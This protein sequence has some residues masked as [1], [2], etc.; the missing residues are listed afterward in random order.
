M[1]IEPQPYG[2]L[3]QYERRTLRQAYVTEQGGLCC[4][5][6]AP[7]SG[8]PLANVLALKINW[9]LFPP[10]FLNYPIHLHHDHKTDLT[11]GAIHAYCNAVSWQYLGE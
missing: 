11:I 2:L 4:H 10:G 6:K 9:N 1:A 8:Q 5:C 3:S 7:L